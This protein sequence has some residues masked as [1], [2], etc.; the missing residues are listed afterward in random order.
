[1]NTNAKILTLMLL[2]LLISNLSAQDD[3]F[4]NDPVVNTQKDDRSFRLGLVF[5]PNISWLKTNTTGYSSDGVRIGFTYGISTEF[6][7]AKNYLLSTGFSINNIG[8]KLRY[9]SIYDNAGVVTASEI[10]QS[11]KINYVD[12]PIALKLRTNEI[13]YLTYYG[14]FG[15]NMGIK[16][17]SKTDIEYLDINNIKQT[18]VNNN[19]SIS[20]ININLVV[21]GGLEYNISGNTNLAV[22]ITFHNGFTNVLRGKTHE[23][24][25]IGKA[26]IDSDGKAVYTDKKVNATL[27]YFSLDFA[28]YF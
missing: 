10:K 19:S 5:A 6:F 21:G 20:L 22:G 3:N 4:K 9:E 28:I 25:T 15:F 18:D 11:I 12:I 27:N 7:L 14:I 23:L 26:L 8:G 16:Y 13:G 1:M 2:G 17:S 24:N